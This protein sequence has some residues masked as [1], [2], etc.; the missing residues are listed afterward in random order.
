MLGTEFRPVACEGV[1]CSRKQRRY[2]KQIKWTKRE[3]RCIILIGQLN[4]DNNREN[5]QE[6]KEFFKEVAD[7]S[8]EGGGEL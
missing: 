7:T 3:I 6:G 1:G 4:P 8:L 5:N 2:S